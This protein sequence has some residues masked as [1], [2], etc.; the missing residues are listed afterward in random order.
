MTEDISAELV[1]DGLADAAGDAYL[2]TDTH[3][4]VQ[5]DHKGQQCDDD[6]SPDIFSGI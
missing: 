2:E 3:T 6:N 1:H 4:S 5:Y